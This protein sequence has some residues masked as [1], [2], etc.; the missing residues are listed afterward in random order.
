MRNLDWVVRRAEEISTEHNSVMKF[1][2]EALITLETER[3]NRNGRWIVE[4]QPNAPFL[5]VGDLHGD[6]STLRA[7]LSRTSHEKLAKGELTLV[8]LGDYIDRGNNQIETFLTVLVLKEE[9]PDSVVLLRGNHEPPENL[10]PYPHDYP[11]VLRSRY[12]YI[13]GLEIYNKSLEI[14]DNLPLVFIV[15]NQFAALHGGLPTETFKKEVSLVE[16]F[17]GKSHG[18]YF[19]VMTEILWN[20]PIESNHYRIPSP[21][22]VGYLFGRPVTE[23]FLHTFRFNA[24]IRGHEAVDNGFKLNHGGRVVTLFSRLGPP[25]Y[26]SRASYMVVDTSIERWWTRIT[27]FI[28][29]LSS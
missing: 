24:V 16:Y 11:S 5:I 2:E 29:S 4:A 12:G 18:E 17:T 3:K 22:G 27:N 9:F 7:I 13:R 28:V 21:R 20:D 19:N 15:R 23:W 6:L 26:N 10:K 25:Y 14:F 1:L 8:F